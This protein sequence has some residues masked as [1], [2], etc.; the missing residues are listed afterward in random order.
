MEKKNNFDVIV[1]GGGPAGMIAA[2]TAAKKGSTVALLEKNASL[3][4]KL[5]M[6]GDGRCNLTHANLNNRE[7]A[8]VF[9]K[10]GD[11]LLSTFARFG[12]KETMD[13]FAQNEVDLKTEVDGRVFPKSDKAQDILKVLVK[14]LKENKV[15]IFFN[16]AVI[17]IEKEKGE[18]MIKSV[19]LANGEKLTAKRYIL[20][21]GGKAYPVTGS[22]GDGY[23]YAQNLGHTIVKPQAALVPVQIKESWTK[24]LSG[25][26]FENARISLMLDGKVIKKKE[27]DIL[28]AHFGLTGPLVLDLSKEIGLT[29]GQGKVKLLVDLYYKKTQE[30]MEMI[31]QKL[32]ESKPKKELKNILSELAPVKLI[33]YI[34]YFAGVKESTLGFEVSKEAREKIVKVIKR[35]EF[36]PISLVGFDRA[37]VTAGGV[38][39]K[40]IDSR[41][42]NSKIINNL[43]FAGEVINLDGPCGG[44]N[45]QMCW[46]TGF[47]AGSN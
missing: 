8:A 44:Y 30:Q 2:I 41:T 11:F 47:V 45:L 28:F 32:I 31:V 43:Y 10:D 3:G 13:F 21:T 38:S 23:A 42:M 36:N 16:S 26:S 33:P 24:N 17:K 5:L 46:S 9:G 34:V 40:E 37:M 6:T 29:M 22:T 27:G 20:T 25:L 7:F 12:M 4:K 1:I 39:L 35:L 19:T 18:K 15:S 14:N